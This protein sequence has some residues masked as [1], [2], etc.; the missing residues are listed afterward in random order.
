MI[1]IKVG[2]EF[3]DIAT[4]EISTKKTSPI[5]TANTIYG[6]FSDLPFQLADTPKNHR[7]INFAGQKASS[8]RDVSISCQVFMDDNF[9]ASGKLILKE[10]AGKIKVVLVTGV[11]ELKEELGTTSLRSISWDAID[12]REPFKPQVYVY[13][14]GSTDDLD[15]YYVDSDHDEWYVAYA[16]HWK[17]LSVPNS[18]DGV[19]LGAY[20]IQEMVDYIN[21]AY[22][23]GSIPFYAARVDNL[24]M[25][26]TH[27]LFYFG[28]FGA[29]EFE[30]S[31]INSQSGFRCD[32]I[33]VGD[34]D[35]LSTWS[36]YLISVDTDEDAP[37]KF[38]VVYNNY[39]ESGQ[40]YINYFAQSEAYT[41]ES[42]NF[43][44]YFRLEY[45][46]LKLFAALGY[47]PTGSLWNDDWF[48]SIILFSNTIFDM[49][50]IVTVWLPEYGN[51]FE[52][53]PGKY[54]P[55]MDASTFLRAIEINLG[56]V[57]FMDA[58]SKTV[59]IQ[60]LKNQLRSNDYF[61][62]Q[63]KLRKPV[64][65]SFSNTFQEGFMLKMS[66]DSQDEVTE[67]F[68][69]YE[70]QSFSQEVEEFGDI[71]SSGAEADD[72]AYVSTERAIYKYN[73]FS[74]VFEARV[75]D[76]Y[77][78][79][80]GKTVYTTAFCEIENIS[81]ADF[82][83]SATRSLLTPHVKQVMAI[84]S[85][86][87]HASSGF[88]EEE[89]F[90][91][92]LLLYHGMQEDSAGN[93]YP[94]ASQDTFIYDGTDLNVKS[95]K[96]AAV[97]SVAADFEAWYAMLQNQSRS[98]ELELTLNATDVKTLT[99]MKVLREREAKY[100]IKELKTAH[101]SAY[102]TAVCVVDAYLV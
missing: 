44:P 29:Q 95:L 36:N 2:D 71:V 1:S 74:W 53:D 87:Y 38:P 33:R 24:T 40:F 57:F 68:V 93:L 62:I 19:D 35:L 101:R 92:K 90:A 13:H 85:A 31:S 22:E 39:Y 26:L 9:L 65:I 49:N 50:R 58:N 20:E 54:M 82:T 23:D 34:T 66:L 80:N 25:I 77:K 55:D 61:E 67:A 99:P 60:F 18:F 59:Q 21:D 84:D 97:H 16:T 73:G 78:I 27:T 5:F 11:S 81:Q 6:D 10:V 72:L 91:P 89:E 86:F 98:A 63:G 70:K 12:F 76:F 8:T 41:N 14:D 102:N 100:L 48:K 3:L 88:N 30:I 69:E 94:F 56:L 47:V 17:T 51:P 43:S 52:I 4:T 83:P 64:K 7:L 15:V 28:D 79:D 46:M 32:E 42:V 37:Y 45:V 75:R 96:F